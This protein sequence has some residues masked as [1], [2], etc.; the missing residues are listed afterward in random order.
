MAQYF[1]DKGANINIQNKEGNTPLHLALKNKHNKVIKI[2]MEKKAALDIPN[3]DGEIPFDY[4]TPDM[5]RDYGVDKILVINPT[6]ELNNYI[7]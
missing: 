1:V 4:F 7:I 2:L 3:S 6:K 5:K